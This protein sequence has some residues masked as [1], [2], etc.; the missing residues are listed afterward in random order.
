MAQPLQSHKP[1]ALSS[2]SSYLS[3]APFPF[4]PTSTPPA[5]IASFAESRLHTLLGNFHAG[6]HEFDCADREHDYE[7][8][9]VFGDSPFPT[10]PSSRRTSF[11]SGLI[12][13]PSFSS[14]TPLDPAQ[15]PISNTFGRAMTPNKPALKDPSQSQST[16]S[17]PLSSGAGLAHQQGALPS[18][19]MQRAQTAPVKVAGFSAQHHEGKTHFDPSRDPKLLG[20]L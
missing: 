6:T 3:Q 7:K 5:H 12:S 14:L 10:P 19:P 1:R 2:S 11:L 15:T 4:T 20:L 13:R 8:N 17:V 16:P 18:I 9:E